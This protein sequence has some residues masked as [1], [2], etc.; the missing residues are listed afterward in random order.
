[1]V[2]ITDAAIKYRTKQ[3]LS[4]ISK[5]PSEIIN[6]VTKPIRDIASGELICWQAYDPDW[7]TDDRGWRYGQTLNFEG[8]LAIQELYVD[9]SG[10]PTPVGD[11]H[12]PR[13]VATTPTQHRGTTRTA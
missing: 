11:P 1:M 2:P 4:I 12:L 3:L 13:H 10:V 9:T 7:Q 8:S 5:I 6:A